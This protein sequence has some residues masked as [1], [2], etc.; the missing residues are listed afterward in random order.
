MS[1]QFKPEDS[2]TKASQNSA[3][4]L[5]GTQWYYWLAASS[6]EKAGKVYV[7]TNWTE[8]EG[9]CQEALQRTEGFLLESGAGDGNRTHVRSL[10]SFYTAIVRRPLNLLTCSIIPKLGQRNFANLLSTRLSQTAAFRNNSTRPSL[11]SEDHLLAA[12]AH[13]SSECHLH[14]APIA[15]PNRPP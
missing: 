5:Y 10:G 7:S 3:A 15:S 2:L 13:R 11:G 12:K 1:D 6:I 9:A 4:Q 14:Y 8:S